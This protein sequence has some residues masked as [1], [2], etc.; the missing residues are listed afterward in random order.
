[1]LV[2]SQTTLRLN[3]NTILAFATFSTQQGGYHQ[4]GE[5]TLCAL[6]RGARA[7]L[8]QPAGALFFDC[9]ANAKM[10]ERETASYLGTH[11][12]SRYFSPSKQEHPEISK[13]S[14]HRGVLITESRK[15][16]ESR[17]EKHLTKMEKSPIRIIW[18]ITH[19]S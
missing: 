1:M 19:E 2:M 11:T 16:F 17:I 18:R 12:S 14:M 9:K 5:G 3:I 10:P 6:W 4:G 13:K 15:E 8:Y 7:D